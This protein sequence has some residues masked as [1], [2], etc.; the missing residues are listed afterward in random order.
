MQTATK[1][2]AFGRVLVTGATG[3]LGRAVAEALEHEGHTVLRGARNRPAAAPA[4]QAWIGHGDIGPQTRWDA[5]LVG[6]E[7]VVHLA[8]AAHL[9]ETT[10]AAS[11]DAFS[12]VNADGTARLASAA[13][14]A[15]IRRLILMSS[16]LV[17][18]AASPLGRPFSEED[19]PAPTNPYA[20]SKLDAERRLMAAARGSGLQWVILRPPMVYGAQ[21][22]GNFQRLVRLLRTGMPLPLG[23]ATAPRTFIGIDNLAHAVVRCVEHQ[24]AVNQVFLVGDREATSTA[25]FVHRIAAALNRRVW[26]PRV[27]PVLLRTGFRLARRERD[28]ERLFDPLE[29]DTRRMRA[30][31]DWIPPMSLDE[32]LAR[33]LRPKSTIATVDPGRPAPR[34][35]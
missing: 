13:V 29:L 22:R 23:A 34:A 5:P 1:R 18:G 28:F 12:R 17:H 7:T 3:F 35:A 24:S 8:G 11:V 31:L 26:T 10:M 33:A 19:E 27:P 4:G 2:E 6:V 20:R 25:D 15:G 30:E 32:G 14:G 16:A 9:P 21:A